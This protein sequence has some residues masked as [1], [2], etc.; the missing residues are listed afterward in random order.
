MYTTGVGVG[1]TVAVCVG[2]GVIVGGNSWV[3]VG[4]KV[5]VG[6]PGVGDMVI[7]TRASVGG[8]VQV[9][10]S[11]RVGESVGVRVGCSPG[12]RARATNPRQ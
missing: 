7:V 5:S 1:I 8:T 3:G 10:L 6:G 11:V 2:V 12:A 4:G 9:G